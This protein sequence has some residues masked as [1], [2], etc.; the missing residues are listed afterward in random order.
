MRLPIL[1]LLG[2]FASV[3]SVI[4]VEPPRGAAPSSE[5]GLVLDSSFQ[6]YTA[7]PGEQTATFT[8]KLTNPTH[9]PIVVTEVRTSCGCSVAKLPADPWMLRPGAS[10]EFQIV[11]DLR[12]KRGVLKKDATIETLRGRQRIDFNI[13]IPE[14]DPREEM[15]QR[16]LLIAQNDRQAVFK[17]DC[18]RCHVE[19]TKG[20]SGRELFTAACVICHT[21]DGHRASM[22]PDLHA[23]SPQ[24]T[25]DGWRSLITHGKSGTLMPAFGAAAGG[26]LTSEQIDSL[27]DY[28]TQQFAA[29][30]AKK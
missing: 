17:G 14:S 18:A 29:G 25:A 12:G 19:P 5:T 1:C 15:R 22:V 16:N 28:L 13:T 24:P 30:A 9:E 4:A 6:E 23:L 7:Q 20:L 27:V 8:F 2:F 26:P 3:L 10:G 11:V 21:A